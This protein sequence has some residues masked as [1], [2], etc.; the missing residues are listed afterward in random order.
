[1][2]KSGYL[3]ITIGFLAGALVAVLDESKILWFYF[4]GALV[5]GIIGIIVV[6]LHERK[7]GRCEKRL[8]TYLQDVK[9]SLSSIVE[10]INQLN[11]E[12][13]SINV[14]DMRQ[15]IDDLFT[16]DL[17]T[18]VEARE[19]LSHI[20]GLQVY[21]DVMSH[22]ASAERYLNRA[23]S[24]SADGY[25]DEVSIYLDRAQVQFVDALNKVRHLRDLNN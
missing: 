10:N 7:S 23:W 1:M 25:I 15:R 19:S 5:F 17:A 20:H 12:K 8:A 16:E 24:A 21:A 18:F 14:Y 2:K 6:H 13:Q 22:F 11:A 9:N 4:S 3:L